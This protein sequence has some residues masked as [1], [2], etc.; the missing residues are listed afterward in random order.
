MPL[1]TFNYTEPSSGIKVANDQIAANS[2]HYQFVKL[3]D[4]TS[5]SETPIFTLTAIADGMA[6][7]NQVTVASRLMF[8]NGATWDMTRGDAAN[9]LWVNV[10]AHVA[11]PTGSNTI[12]NV[13]TIATSVTPG[14]SAAHLGKA[15]DAVHAS[16]DTGL[17]VLS[18]R[19]DTATQLAGSDGDY[20]PTITDASGRLHVNVGA[21]PARAATTDTI[22]AK[23][24]TDAIQ[25]GTTA[26]TPKFAK[27]DC[28]TSGDNT[29]LAAV[30]AKK[31]RV[32]SYLINSAGAVN[33]KFQSGASGTDLMGAAAI[34]AN[35]NLSASFSPVGHFETAVTTLLNL[36]LSAAIQISGHIAYVEV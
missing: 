23:L 22:T 35:S 18:V 36:N 12:G 6:N 1:N 32:L 26:L 19:K 2:N 20:A 16:G 8:Y 24:A 27:I 34:V 31:I 30:S 17:F 9:G 7:Y 14:T 21:Q 11:L 15:E 28:A 33:A 25:N 3:A 13:G 5:D 29:I 4:G 10:K